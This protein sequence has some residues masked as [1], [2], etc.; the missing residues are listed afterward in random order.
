M[1]R[2]ITLGLALFGLLVINSSCEKDDLCP[3]DF[4]ATP[5]LFIQFK[6]ANNPTVA[7]A[8]NN[9]TIIETESGEPIP[10]NTTGSTVL[11]NISE[12]SI[13]INA[14]DIKTNFIFRRTDNNSVINEDP[15][16]FDY[17][18]NLEY[19]NRACGYRYTYS[20]LVATRENET[21]LNYWIRSLIVR[22]SEVTSNLDV[23]VE[24]FH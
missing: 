13:P 17:S 15:I 5:R 21:P 4:I 2:F 3:S 14:L 9:L 11:T 12:I 19:L 22:N 24:I 23:H 1:N 18:T 16:S 20:N 10:L 6:D 8:V 7:K